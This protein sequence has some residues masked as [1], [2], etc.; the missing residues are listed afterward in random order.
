ML[1][2]VFVNFLK[3]VIGNVISNIQFAFVKG[4]K[5][6]DGIL[7]VNEVGDEVKR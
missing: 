5:I 4:R 6:L 2:K 3:I 1:D 7:I